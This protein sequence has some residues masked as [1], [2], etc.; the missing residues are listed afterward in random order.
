MINLKRIS[1]DSDVIA[2][3]TTKLNPSDSSKPNNPYSNSM[4]AKATNQDAYMR[5][6]GTIFIPAEIKYSKK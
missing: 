6:D 3:E 1:S 4:V 5:S 2:V